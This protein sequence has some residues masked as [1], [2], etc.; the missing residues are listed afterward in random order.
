MNCTEQLALRGADGS[1][2]KALSMPLPTCMC[3]SFIYLC[4]VSRVD[5]VLHLPGTG[6]HCPVICS[7]RAQ[8]PSTCRCLRDTCPP[9]TE[10]GRSH[11]GVV[12]R[13][14]AR[15]PVETGP[16]LGLPQAAPST[17]HRAPG[18]T[19]AA[20][21]WLSGTHKIPVYAG[22]CR[23][24]LSTTWLHNRGSKETQSNKFKF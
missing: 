9:A 22:G 24:S 6:S 21:T 23:L 11:P 20:L 3:R 15:I 2:A 17:S 16:S 4:P 7:V 10:E 5:K 8:T 14:E 1:Q 12:V 13:G 19:W 18:V